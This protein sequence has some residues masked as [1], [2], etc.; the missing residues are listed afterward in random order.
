MPG[1]NHTMAKEAETE[2]GTISTYDGVVLAQSVKNDD[3]S[4]DR[5]YPA[6]DLAAHVVGYASEQYGTSGIEA[7]YNDTLKG[8]QNFATWSDAVNA[9]AGINQ[10][11]NDVT[12][13]INSKIQQA[14]QDALSGYSG[15]L[16]GHRPDHRS[17]AG[18]GVLAHL[19]RRRC[20]NPHRTGVDQRRR[21]GHAAQPRDAIA[22]RTGL[23]L[24]DGV[25]FHRLRRRRRGRE[26]GVRLAGSME[27]GNAPVTNF[28]EY[29]YGNITLARATGSPRTPS[30]ASSA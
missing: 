6:G 24:Q 30:T 19:R 5:V 13:T 28:G 16:R 21:L 23:D 18:H 29:A 10:P 8:N 26:H 22:L 17:R 3:G 27:I 25:A 15:G 4:Y 7:A 9:L 14:A 2:R 20:G 1:N 11:G 12:L